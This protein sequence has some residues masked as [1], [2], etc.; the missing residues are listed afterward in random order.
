VVFGEHGLGALGRDSC[1]GGVGEELRAGVVGD[2]HLRGLL[3][4]GAGER[5]CVGGLAGG[6]SPLCLVASCLSG[7]GLGLAQ[8]RGLML[9][10]SGLAGAGQFVAD[11]AGPHAF[12]RSQARTRIRSCPPDSS[13]SSRSISG[14]PRVRQ[15]ARYAA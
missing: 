9:T 12:S 10:R 13:V 4:E 14:R 6:P 7:V 3:V 2:L 8:R 1:H 11:V 5:D 15:A